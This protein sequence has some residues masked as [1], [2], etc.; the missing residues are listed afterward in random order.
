[1]IVIAFAGM[2]GSGKG[3]AMKIAHEYDI[4][5]VRMGDLVWEET[6]RKDLELTS[7]N[8]ARVA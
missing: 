6:K 7:W 4:P 3:E 2:A 5:V 8:V 1:M